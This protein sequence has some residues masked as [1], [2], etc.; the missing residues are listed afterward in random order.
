MSLGDFMNDSGASVRRRPTTS[1]TTHHSPKNMLTYRIGFG[2]GSWADEVE[3]T[4]GKQR[5]Y[6]LPPRLVCA[7]T[8]SL[9]SLVR[10]M[11]YLGRRTRTDGN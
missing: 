10:F 2:G 11:R 1:A 6:R 4:Y 5:L 9:Q 3:E 7:Y 8:N